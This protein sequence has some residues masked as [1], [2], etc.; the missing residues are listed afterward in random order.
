MCENK[1][2]FRDHQTGLVTPAFRILCEKGKKTFSRAG[3]RRV[4]LNVVGRE[5]LLQR[6]EVAISKTLRENFENDRF[7][8]LRLRHIN[9]HSRR[10][11]LATAPRTV[12]TRMT[13][14]V[15][16]DRGARDT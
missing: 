13:D 10:R 12:L 5:P 1:I 6:R 3:N 11:M 4:V 16:S 9:L 7:V 15:V 8:A 14:F 2:V